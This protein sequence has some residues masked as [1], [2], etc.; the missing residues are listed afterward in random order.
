MTTE[1]MIE[2]LLEV[3]MKAYKKRSE[4]SFIASKLYRHEPV[5]VEGI[6]FSYWR[7]Y[8]VYKV[9]K[10]VKSE[11]PNANIELYL[12]QNDSYFTLELSDEEQKKFNSKIYNFLKQHSSLTT[13]TI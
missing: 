7:E 11:I 8:V 3:C 6:T 5:E 12:I 4:H 13:K 9:A 1:D 10:Y 2:T